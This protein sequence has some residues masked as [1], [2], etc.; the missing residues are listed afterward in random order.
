MDD[1]QGDGHSYV[2]GISPNEK[3]VLS[4]VHWYLN[5]FCAPRAA[6]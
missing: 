4:G 3:H 1:H 5:G 2:S 6:L